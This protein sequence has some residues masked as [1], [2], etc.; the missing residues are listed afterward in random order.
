MLAT[1]GQLRPALVSTT[2]SEKLVG[3][4]IGKARLIREGEE[5]QEAFTLI[6][7]FDNQIGAADMALIATEDALLLI[8]PDAAVTRQDVAAPD[9][10]DQMPEGPVTGNLAKIVDPLRRLLVRTEGVFSC[11][12]LKMVDD[13][14]KTVARCR[15]QSFA[16]ENGT[17]ACMIEF[18]PLRGYDE[19]M[20]QLTAY[21]ASLGKPLGTVGDIARALRGPGADYTSKP[22]IEMTPEES[23]FQ[24]ATD[25]IRAQIAVARANEPGVIEDIDS[26]FLHDYRVALRRTRSV[27]S[28]FKGV[29]TDQQTQQFKD[30]F[31]SLMA[32]TGEL[33]DL[34]VH[35]LDRQPY[36]ELV[37]PA[38]QP[39]IDKLFDSLAA[40]RGAA[41]AKLARFFNGQAYLRE[42]DK[43]EK[44]FAAPKRIAKGPEAE[45]PALAF[46]QALI[47]KR[48]VKVCKIAGSIDD[49]TPDEQ[50]HDLRIHCKKLRYLI[51]FFAPL[52]GKEDTKVMLKSLKKLQDNLG[53]FNDYSVQQEALAGMLD[54][55]SDGDSTDAI[56][57]ATSIGALVTVLHQKQIEERARVVAS[58]VAF[59]SD[60]TRARF[61]KSFKP[62]K[63]AA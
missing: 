10:V 56:E 7:T 1:L 39:G 2:L 26:E 49:A 24:A 52:F 16:P 30:R 38:L 58:F 34:D 41:H 55:L 22:V 37:P 6:D 20:E 46:A 45:R 11:Q 33:R 50:V 21:V 47:W 14:D 62:G 4:K 18:M 44:L 63:T 48:Y 43:L 54:G 28:L 32:R 12:I 15:V 61:R 9:F 60:K 13:L 53:A 57:I 42:M 5:E 59:N 3:A 25:I 17:A 31:G 40:D 29:F 36:R 27:V 51:E 23:S 8:G 35:L 19:E